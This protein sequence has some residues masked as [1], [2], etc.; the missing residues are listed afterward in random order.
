MIGEN[1]VKLQITVTKELDNIL[2]QIIEGAKK[3]N[4]PLTKSQLVEVALRK[5]ISESMQL[6]ENK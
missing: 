5:F 3:V 4:N 6:K 1:K 2:N